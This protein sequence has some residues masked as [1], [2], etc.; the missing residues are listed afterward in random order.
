MAHT[1]NHTINKR[2]KILPFELKGRLKWK[3]EEGIL[4]RGK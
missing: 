3:M 1:S 4:F 2:K